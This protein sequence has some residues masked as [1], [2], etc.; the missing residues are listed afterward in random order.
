MPDDAPE[1]ISITLDGRVV[2]ASSGELLIEVAEQAGVEIPRFCYHPRMEPVGV[3]RMCLV[4]V[5]GP[6]GS[7]L[8]PSCFMQ[9]TDGM[10]VHTNTEKVT[11]AQDG[12]LE[13]LLANHP[14]DCPICDKGGECSLQDQTIEFGPGASRFTEEKRHYEKPI[15]VSSLVLLD[16]ERCIQCSRCTRFAD[17]IAGEPLIEFIGRGDEIE[18]ATFPG[19]PF[20]SYFSGNTVQICP[21]GALTASPYRFAARP[22]DLEQVESTCTGCSVGCRIVVQSSAGQITRFLG[23]DVDA[24]NQGWLCDKG[25]FLY[26]SLNGPERGEP[27]P[28]LLDPA[29]RLTEPLV[30]VDG[31]LTPVSW[32]EALRHAASLITEATR[33]SAKGIGVLGGSA[34]SNE[35]A[36]AFASLFKGVVGTDSV[37]AQFGDG[38]DPAHLFGLP[39]A[40]LDDVDRASA[41]LL[42][43]GDLREDVPVAFLRLRGAATSKKVP[44]IDAGPA[45]GSLSPVS[46]VRLHA[47][48]GDALAIAQA[49]SGDDA[50][51]TLLLS[52]PEGPAFSRDD[53]RRAQNL[54]ESTD[55][56]EG[57][58]VVLGRSSVA[59][60]P[61]ITE[62]AARHLARTFPKARFLPVLRRANVIGALDMGLTPGFAPGRVPLASASAAL[63]DAWR[64]L[65]DERGRSCTEQLEALGSGAQRA[66]VLL[67][68]DL[69]GNVPDAS[70][71]ER[72]LSTKPPVLVIS[73]H[74][75][76]MLAH[77]S[78]VL[79]ATAAHERDGSTTNLEGRISA[80]VQK[81]PPKGSAWADWAIASELGNELGHDLGF[82]TVDSVTDAI[83]ELAPSHGHITTSLLRL[84]THGGGV[85]V[86]LRSLPGA[87][88]RGADPIAASGFTADAIHDASRSEDGSSTGSRPDPLVLSTPDLAGV[89]DMIHDTVDPV[90]PA[91][92]SYSLRLVAPHVLYDGGATVSASPSLVALRQDAIASVNPYDLDRIGVSSGG[93]VRLRRA[94]NSAVVHVRAD[95]AIL[96]GTI[97]IPFACPDPIDSS[98]TNLAALLIS[99]DDLICELRMES[100]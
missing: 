31:H 86:P 66:L 19:E 91:P 58:V 44:L 85:V 22:W 92:D 93:R 81:Q 14:L 16:R 75:G 1:A 78:V 5:E 37:D 42:L 40:S 51:A 45:V 32:S 71:V 17:E 88:A 95:D 20:A 62:A 94:T 97:S 77:A 90:V 47:R 4:E 67:G 13:F 100:I 55:A 27:V 48:P 83:A 12:V 50:A 7:A 80:L 74:G 2:S 72:A 60:S 99:A 57:I 10:V 73:S 59:E 54:L 89:D 68:S 46:S 52:H 56:G 63:A 33:S 24:V 26:E 30:R 36:F 39:R 70:L 38:L 49:L 84:T 53:L 25:R 6:R 64:V 28:D 43:C 8:M 21:V 69:E 87:P 23:V 9:A 15:E 18:V 82:T 65:P 61:S 11:K 79:P 29:R 35:G 98:I 41:V 3:C 76:P 34:L 96:R